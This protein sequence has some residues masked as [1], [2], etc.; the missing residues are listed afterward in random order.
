MNKI[1]LIFILSTFIIGCGPKYSDMISTIQMTNDST[2]GYTA[3]NPIQI[4]YSKQQESIRYSYDFL[5]R[6]RNK[7]GAPFEIIGRVS[8]KNPSYK[9]SLFPRRRGYPGV[10][11]DNG[12][13]DVYSLIAVG[14]VDTIVLYIDIYNKE[15]L[16]IPRGMKFII[17]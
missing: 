17:E 14:T 8:I 10:E 6:L 11:I 13:L 5:S 9:P 1:F 2:Y 3:Q 16:Y 12:M 7:D 15:Q 4:G